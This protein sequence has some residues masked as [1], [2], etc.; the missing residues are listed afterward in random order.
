MGQL[1]IDEDNLPEMQEAFAAARLKN[2][3]DAKSLYLLE[4]DLLSKNDYIVAALALLNKA[5]EEHETDINLLYSRAMISEK[6]NDLA[7]MENDLRTILG[8]EPDNAMVLNAL[9]YTLVD[10]TDRYH[11][12][13]ELIKRANELKPNDPAITDSLGWAMFRLGNYQEAIRLLEKAL[14]DF[15]DHEV[16]AHLGEVLWYTGEHDRAREVWRE[17]LERRPDSKILKRVIERL[18]PQMQ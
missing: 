3:D 1:F 16:A 9:G 8:M 2:S 15:P 13:L 4:A 5:L 11:E 7:S 12:A 10:R 6:A 18:A 14:A 17:A